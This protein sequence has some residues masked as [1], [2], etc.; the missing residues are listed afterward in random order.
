VL[1]CDNASYFKDQRFRAM[2]ESSGARLL[3][4]DPHAKHENPIEESF[5]KVKATLLRNLELTHRDPVQSLRAAFDSITEE[6]VVGYYRHA[7]FRIEETVI[8]PGIL[9]MYEDAHEGAAMGG[10]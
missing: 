6:D 7:G 9:T 1:V 10:V 4:L 3:Y 8:I 2:I 5:S